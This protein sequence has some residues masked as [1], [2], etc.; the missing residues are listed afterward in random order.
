MDDL[1]ATL[2]HRFHTVRYDGAQ[3]PNG[4]HDLSGGA[5]CQRYAYAVLANFG[6]DLPPWRSSELWA[7]AERTQVVSAFEPLDLLLFSRDGQPFGAHVAVYAGEGRVLHLAKSVGKP[8]VWSLTEFA[9]REE[10]R[11]LLGGKRVRPSFAKRVAAI[12]V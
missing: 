11:A 8:V 10:Y 9:G 4:D 6:I 7:D 1:L 2:P 12:S 5:N 3:I